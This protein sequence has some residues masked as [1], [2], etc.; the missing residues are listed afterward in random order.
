MLDCIHVVTTEYTEKQTKNF[1]NG[2]INY[3][4]DKALFAP[5]KQMHIIFALR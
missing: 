2:K 5:E 3:N 1:L 4:Y